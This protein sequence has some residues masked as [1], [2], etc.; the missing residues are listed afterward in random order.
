QSRPLPVRLTLIMAL[1]LGFGAFMLVSAY[2]SR[3]DAQEMLANGK[4]AVADITRAF[5]EVKNPGEAPSY[6]IELAWTDKNGQRHVYGPTHISGT[7]YQQITSNNMQRVKQTTIR[8]LDAKPDVRP[9][10]IGDAS[11]RQ[12]QDSFGV[13]AGAVFLA[14]GVI[15]LGGILVYRLRAV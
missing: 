10:I 15:L 6:L 3:R 7:F 4:E 12:F 1:M 2:F 14:I 5:S 13:E 11:E 9:L 8:Y